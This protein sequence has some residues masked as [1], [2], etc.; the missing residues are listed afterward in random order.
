MWRGSVDTWR[1]NCPF[2]SSNCCEKSFECCLRA[3]AEKLL[4]QVSNADPRKVEGY[5]FRKLENLLTEVGQYRLEYELEPSVPGR[6]PLK[7]STH[8]QV[9]PGPAKYFK[10]TVRSFCHH[11]A[12]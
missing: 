2:K 8:I 5:Y 6:D 10:I 12:C 3:C 4:N 7:I 9:S 1:A 11:L